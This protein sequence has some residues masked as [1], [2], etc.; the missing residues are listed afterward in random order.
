MCGQQGDLAASGQGDGFPKTDR[1]KAKEGLPAIR[2]RREVRPDEPVENVRTED[3]QRFGQGEHGKLAPPCL[4]YR[5][6]QQRQQR[7]VVQVGVRDEYPIDAQQVLVLEFAN[8]GAAMKRDKEIL[9]KAAVY[10]AK[11]E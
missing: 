7:N 5:I 11:D 4:R 8:P 6:H 9:K 10:F 3:V 1:L 2:N